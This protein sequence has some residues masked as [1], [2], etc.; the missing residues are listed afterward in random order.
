VRQHAGGYRYCMR[1]EMKRDRA[2]LRGTRR[3]VGER[4]IALQ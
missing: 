1:D 2:P 4:L 3:F